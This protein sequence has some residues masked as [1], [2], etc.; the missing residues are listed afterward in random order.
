LWS[1]FW[2]TETIGGSKGS[3][4]NISETYYGK[5]QLLIAMPYSIDLST[6]KEKATI[7]EIESLQ[8]TLNLAMLVCVQVQ[9]FN[10]FH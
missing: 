7:E 6:G 1:I 4:G 5:K 10:L 2:S 9:F 3:V 8:N